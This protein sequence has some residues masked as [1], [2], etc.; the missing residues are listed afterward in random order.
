MKSR[1]S[2]SEEE[3]ERIKIGAQL[4]EELRYAREAVGFFSDMERNARSQYRMEI[5]IM[6][7]NE[8]T[9]AIT[10]DIENG[11]YS[12]NY[13]NALRMFDMPNAKAKKEEKDSHEA[14]RNA[15]K[16]YLQIRLALSA[17]MPAQA[18]A[19]FTAITLN[20][21][22]TTIVEAVDFH[23]RQTEALECIKH[24]QLIIIPSEHELSGKSVPILNTTTSALQS[25]AHKAARLGERPTVLPFSYVCSIEPGKRGGGKNSITLAY[26]SPK[27]MSDGIGLKAI[28][29]LVE[30]GYEPFVREGKNSPNAFNRIKIIA[31][32]VQLDKTVTNDLLTDVTED[33]EGKQIIERWLD[34]AFDSPKFDEDGRI[35]NSIFE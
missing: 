22:W 20:A 2:Y 28:K 9:K 26:S 13:T 10:A 33:N 11:I 19:A 31:R 25:S 32:L 4:E 21:D 27:D 18:S 3:Y 23:F 17:G 24:N 35:E 34:T 5:R 29:G 15:A 14:L 1:G 7:M 16:E 8:L 12:T 30:C 6:D